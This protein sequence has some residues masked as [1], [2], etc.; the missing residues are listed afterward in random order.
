MLRKIETPKFTKST[1]DM[2]IKHC[3]SISYD[4]MQIQA[5]LVM[6][7]LKTEQTRMAVAKLKN[8]TAVKKVEALQLEVELQSGNGAVNK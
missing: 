4:T 7:Q 5:Q 1:I 6:V 2:L 8:D 3:E